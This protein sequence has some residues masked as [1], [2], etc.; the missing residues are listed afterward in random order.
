[1]GALISDSIV[2]AARL[3][4]CRGS[5]AVPPCDQLQVLPGAIIRCRDCG[6]FLNIKA[7]VKLAKCPRS[8]WPGEKSN[9]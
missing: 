6:C 7:W 9:A 3:A 2:A 4:V 5:G 8:K 1:M